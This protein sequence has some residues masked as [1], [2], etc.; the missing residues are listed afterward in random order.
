[1]SSDLH[2]G[3][4][5]T[6][7]KP[8]SFISHLLG[9]LKAGHRDVMIAADVLHEKQWTAPWDQAPSSGSSKSRRG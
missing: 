1:M 2:P 3:S 4:P 6:T 9:W 5:G 8:A 7:H